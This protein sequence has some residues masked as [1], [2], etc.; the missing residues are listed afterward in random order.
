MR[1][2]SAAAQQRSSAAARQR[3]DPGISESAPNPGAL[4]LIVLG[5]QGAILQLAKCGLDVNSFVD[6]FVHRL[7]NGHLNPKSFS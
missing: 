4:I 7:A 6:D 1:Q 5:S 3:S 2:S